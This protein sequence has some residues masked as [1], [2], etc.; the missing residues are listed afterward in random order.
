MQSTSTTGLI[1]RTTP[2]S[3]T[4]TFFSVQ[5]ASPDAVGAS[6]SLGAIVASDT[7]ERRSCSINEAIEESRAAYHLRL[8]A[9]R[10][11]RFDSPKSSDSRSARR[12]SEPALNSRAQQ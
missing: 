12:S 6:G 2:F 4:L 7:R 3:L 1:N 11:C 8:A 9:W 10:M 5:D